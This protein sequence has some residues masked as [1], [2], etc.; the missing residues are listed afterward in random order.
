MFARTGLRVVF[1]SLLCAAPLAGGQT[2]IEPLNQVVA[3]AGV[4]RKVH[5]YGPP[6][7]GEDKKTD[8]RITY[9]VL[10]VPT[11]VNTFCKPDR[12]E[13]RSI[14][15]RATKR[16]RL[17]FPTSPP[18]NGLELKAK[19]LES[20]EAVVNGVL[21]RQDTLGQITP[22]Y[23]NVTDVQPSQLKKRR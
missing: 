4:I 23:M 2:I 3:L 12:P 5:G 7:Y 15:C 17:F 19:K 21:H 20:H 10:D 18:N 14:Q 9:W 22:I 6:G 11:A 8:R 16:L 13:W 1:L